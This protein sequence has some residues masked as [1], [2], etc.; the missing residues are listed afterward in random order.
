M[1]AVPLFILLGFY[2]TCL[3]GEGKMVF[4]PHISASWQDNTNFWRAE[5]KEKEVFTYLVEPGFSFGYKTDKSQIQ[6]DYTLNWYTY[7]DQDASVPGIR[8][9]SDDNYIGH[10]LN[11]IAFTRQYQQRLLAVVR[12]DFYLTR[13]PAE[14]DTFNNS[15]LREKYYINRVEPFVLYAFTDKITAGLR[16]R[17]T[18]TNYTESGWED[19]LENRGIADLIYNFSDTSSL[20]LGYQIWARDYNQDTSDY[21]SNQILLTFRK[22]F[23]RIALEVGGGYQHRSFDESDL[24]N[25]DVFPWEVSIEYSTEPIPIS[26]LLP[27]EKRRETYASFT[28]S[29]NFNDQGIGES[30]FKGTRFTLQAGHVFL[31]R[32]YVDFEG[33]YQRSKYE[34]WSGITDSGDWARRDDDTYKA[35]CSIGYRFLR[36]FTLSIEPGYEKRDSNIR[37]RSYEDKSIMAM[38]EFRYDTSA[39]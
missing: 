20:T 4:K 17:N 25:I 35:S 10:T 34:F 26:P 11:M 29:R 14:S 27:E 18:I 6:L 13:D 36:W 30:Y 32:I 37:G 24:D 5:N 31:K 16:Y 28:F 2:Q 1:V 12:E 15:V 8:K 23:R 22:Q 38:L 33:Y 3:G 19:S 9:A 7:S 39:K 21:L